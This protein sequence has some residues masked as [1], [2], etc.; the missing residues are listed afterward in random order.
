MTEHTCLG[1]LKEG[2]MIEPESTEPTRECFVCHKH[3]GEIAA[4]RGAAQAI[5]AF[6]ERLRASLY[7]L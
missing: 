1:L 4:P 5:A 3:R 2:V 7:S 6:C